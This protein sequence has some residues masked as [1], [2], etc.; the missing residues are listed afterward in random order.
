MR[1]KKLMKKGGDPPIGNVLYQYEINIDDAAPED[2]LFNTIIN[3]LTGSAEAASSPSDSNTLKN[4]AKII[5]FLRELNNPTNTPQHKEYNNDRKNIFTNIGAIVKEYIP[6]A[7]RVSGMNFQTAKFERNTTPTADSNQTLFGL[8]ELFNKETNQRYITIDPTIIQIM[9]FD[10]DTKDTED[11]EDTEDPADANKEKPADANKEKPEIVYSLKLII[12]ERNHLTLRYTTQLFPINNDDYASKICKYNFLSEFKKFN[13]SLDNKNE[14]QYNNELSLFLKKYIQFY[15]FYKKCY[16]IDAYNKT[17]IDYQ[18]KYISILGKARFRD[19]EVINKTSTLTDYVM[20]NLIFTSPS[21]GFISG[22]YK[23]FKDNAYGITR[24]GYEIAKKY[25]RPILTIMCKEGMHDAHE[26]SDATLI[27]G[28]H[29]GEDTIALS[30]FTDGAIIIAPFGGWT[31]VECLALLAQKKVVG[32]YNDFFNILNYEKSKTPEI[33]ETEAQRIIKVEEAA[34][35]EETTAAYENLSTVEKK[36]IITQQNNEDKTIKDKRAARLARMTRPEQILFES[37]EERV[38]R[39][40]AE[41]AAAEIAKIA[42]EKL[43][44]KVKTLTDINSNKVLNKNFFKFAPSEQK[45]IIDYYINYYLILYIILNK[46][47]ELQIGTIDKINDIYICIDYGIKILMRLK[48]LRGREETAFN[49][50]LTAFKKKIKDIEGDITEMDQFINIALKNRSPTTSIIN[51]YNADNPF[52]EDFIT[53]ISYFNTLKTAINNFVDANLSDINTAY[54]EFCGG[55][56]R[57]QY[58]IPKKCD[59]IWIK[60]KYDLIGKY[61]RNKTASP[62]ASSAAGD[63]AAASA[64]GDE[65]TQFGGAKR[66]KSRKGGTCTATINSITSKDIDGEL[67]KY[68]INYADLKQ[69]NIFKKLNTNII[70]VFSDVM[71]LNLYLNT[72]LNKSSFQ[73]KMQDRINEL[74]RYIDPSNSNSR[75]NLLSNIDNKIKTINLNRNLDGIYDPQTKK[76]I[77]HHIIK[78]T[79]SFTIDEKCNDYTNVICNTE[80]PLTRS[81]AGLDIQ[82]DPK[83]IDV[84][85]T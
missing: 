43:K 66:R 61:I 9:I 22:G 80:R 84:V 79:Y 25:N 50:K 36:A 6:K 58:E 75:L 37:V 73:R 47:Q 27:Y 18:L 49:T 69:N 59:G 70:F 11:T 55:N 46:Y 51:E 67:E 62:A 81:P 13:L 48:D 8:Y 76:I 7:A 52:G 44:K 82:N 3:N 72:N 26:Y 20:S 56:D 17:L 2:F 45:S 63:E 38:N 57:Y 15:Q 71:Y 74:L 42:T 83:L 64:A 34:I 31:Y 68:V 1:S 41:K 40:A 21:Y 39:I 35:V 53:L 4:V 29:W 28:E 23:G 65:A 19:L 85:D 77:N 5:A 33:L 54:I 78:D 24:S 12:R 30:Q 16:K 14:D 32:I 60:P 10:A